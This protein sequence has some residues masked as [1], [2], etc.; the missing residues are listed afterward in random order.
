M[1]RRKGLLSRF[2][3]QER[4]RCIVF[5]SNCAGATYEELKMEG[6]F[7]DDSLKN[8]KW[9]RLH[10]PIEL[11]VEKKLGVGTYYV[12]MLSD[13]LGSTCA[14]THPE[15]DKLVATTDSRRVWNIME[16]NLLHDLTDLKPKTLAL[17]ALFLLGLIS[18]IF[19]K[20]MF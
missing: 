7:I 10:S 15:S 12:Y 9:V 5:R 13:D 2:S 4:A 18:G 1:A 17:I 20:C 14:I 16:N 6:D 19:L 3:R 8:R 11:K